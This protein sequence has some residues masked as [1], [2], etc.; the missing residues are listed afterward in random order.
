MENFD[1]HYFIQDAREKLRDKDATR[2]AVIHTGVMV[3]A[4]LLLMLLQLMMA[5][6]MGKPAGLSGLGTVSLLQTA[7][8]VL[9]TANTLL[10]PFWNLGFLYVALLWARDAA[11]RKEDL[12]MGFRR[13]SPCIGLLLNRF[14][15][16]FGVLFAC[17]YVCSAGFIVTPTGQQLQQVLMDSGMDPM[18]MSDY[19][20]SMSIA[21]ME[22]TLLA[23]L[24]MLIIWAVVSIGLL[25][26]IFYR[27]RMAEFVI[28]D[29]P[30]VRGLPAMV[31]SAG[32]LRRRCWQ[33]F[34]LDLRFW[35]YYGLKLVCMLLC[36]G[37]VLLQLMGAELP[38][39]ADVASMASYVVYLA[40]FF[41][42]EVCFRPRVS[43]AYAR[44]Y[45]A[46]KEMGP[47]P[48]K[49]APAVPREMPWSE[50]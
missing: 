43:T 13:I 10:T 44:F 39:P 26:P 4:G 23:M 41:C 27:F 3:A 21:Q 29:H 11:G 19:V 48:R 31:M 14:L 18:E 38:L 2:M 6:A 25:V 20:N 42:V 5:E 33:L 9:Q 16:G 8:T 24:P 35:W 50:Q 22:P 47:A 40:A 45:D 34:K 7:Q 49:T 1:L 32:L 12:L 17:A 37:D 36:Y 28:L 30:G 15:I 46:L